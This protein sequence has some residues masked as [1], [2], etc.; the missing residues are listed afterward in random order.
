MTQVCQKLDKYYLHI[1]K[2]TWFVE[3]HPIPLTLF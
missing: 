1:N 2:L 3:K